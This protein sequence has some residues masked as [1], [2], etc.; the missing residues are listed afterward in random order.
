[1]HFLT[2]AHL[3]LVGCLW[4]V[5]CANHFPETHSPA[6]TSSSKQLA[7]PFIVQDD[8]YCAPS[9]LAMVLA[10]QNKTVPVSLLAQEMLLPAR[11]G[12][13]QAEL[14][15]SVRR[16]GYLAYETDPTLLA[17]LT[18]V[19]AGRPV[20]V[21]LNLSFNWYPK[22]HY[23]VVTGYDLPR[24]EIIVHS[25]AQANQHWSLTQFDNLWQR[26]NRW[27]LLVLAPSVLPPSSMQET[28]YLQSIVDLEKTAG[29]AQA[30]LA[31]QATL[32]RWPRN[33]TALIGLGNAAYQQHDLALA[34]HWFQLAA[35]YHPDSAVAANNYAQ[36]LLDNGDPAKAFVWAQKAV[37][38]DGGA[39]ARDTLQQVLHALRAQ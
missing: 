19:N 2:K 1:M 38:A 30:Q 17:L 5:G 11:G 28:R 24:Q 36:T 22:W 15:A 9:A 20:I 26:S 34:Q 25:G 12:A 37:L 18:E 32:Q 31:Y 27:G 14:K 39:P 21:L 3:L 7:V 10:Q 35:S 4:L 29:L 6:I 16:Q 8:A 23:A 33:L 13:L